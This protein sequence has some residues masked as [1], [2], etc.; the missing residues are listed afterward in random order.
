VELLVMRHGVAEDKESFATTGED[1]SLL[2]LTK[3]GRW[4]LE[5]ATKGLRRLLSS[6][7]V[8][9][10]SPFTR[11]EQTA[12]ILAAE[13]DCATVERLDA[14]TPDG[15][16][17]KFMAWL[18]QRESNDRVAAVG[19]DPQL[20]SLVSWLVTGEAVEGRILLR[21]GG[22]CLLQFDGQPRMGKAMLIWALTPAIVR[23]LAR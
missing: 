19:H 9:A 10:T 23:R 7:D 8:I 4:K 15:T 18:R 5:Q 1:D 13:Y 14:L 16:P 22:A 12:K 3:E 20:T 17:Q 2:S 6:L 11:A 21:K